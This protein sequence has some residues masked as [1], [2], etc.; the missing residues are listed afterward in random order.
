MKK[1][2]LLSALPLLLPVAFQPTAG[3]AEAG[4]ADAPH[5]VLGIGAPVRGEITTAHRINYSDGSRSIVYGIDLDAGQAVRFETGGALCARLTVLHEGEAVAGPT[6]PDCDDAGGNQGASLSMMAADKGRYQVAVSGAG[7]RAYGPFRLEA[8]ALQVH[9]GDGPLRVGADIVDFL[10]GDARAYRLDIRQSGYYVIDMRSTE[11]DS[12]LELRGNGVSV[13]DDDGGDGLDSRIRV[14]LEPGSYTLRARSVG[15][16]ASGMFQL[17]VSTGSLPAGVTLRNSGALALDGTRI[18]GV[19]GGSPREYQ[20]RVAQPGRVTIDLGSEDF[21]TV[22]E[23]HGNGVA[24]EN[25]DGGDGTNSRLSA[26]LQP[27][28]YRVIA[29]GLHDSASGLFELSATR[30]DLPAGT[31]LRSGGDLSLD[32]AI[33]GMSNGEAQTYRLAIAHPGRLVVDMTS[34]DFDAV[35]ELHR[36]GSKIAEDD[37][38][39]GDTNARLST[40]VQPGDYSIVARSYDG[41]TGGLYELSARLGADDGN[42]TTDVAAPGD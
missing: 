16:A 18:H 5:P 34:E 40:A 20:L 35:L 39:G 4:T 25:D 19:L 13:S 26:A 33:T 17:A 15:G 36:D 3:A 23:L 6:A 27:G 7:H 2:L 11:L 24:L 32:T 14:P 28:S 9:R 37:D 21:D 41:S 12:A 42:V 38:G 1:T 10:R 22:L 29:R 31:S 8:Q 30:R